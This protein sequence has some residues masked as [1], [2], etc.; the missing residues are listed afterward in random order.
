MIKET[1][2]FAVTFYVSA[3]DEEEVR[4]WILDTL[5]SGEYYMSIEIDNYNTVHEGR[6]HKYG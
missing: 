5:D 3:E 6:E 2:K 4:N 1:Q